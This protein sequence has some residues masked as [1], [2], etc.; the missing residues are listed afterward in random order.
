LSVRARALL[1]ALFFFLTMASYY[2]LKPVR[3]AIFLNTQG[4]DKV[5]HSHIAVSIVSFFAVQ[6]YAMVARRVPGRQLVVWINWLFVASILGFRGV[7]DWQPAGEAQTAFAWAYYI[8]VSIF[9]VFAVTLFWSFAHDVFTSDEGSRFYGY[10]GAGGILG[11]FLG[12]LATEH[13][14]NLVGLS[15]MFL[16]SAALLAPCGMIARYV[17]DRVPSTGGAKKGKGEASLGAVELFGKS[18]Y[19]CGIL[20]LV[21]LYQALAVLVDYQTKLVVKDAYRSTAEIAQFYGKIYWRVNILGTL[22]NLALTGFLQTRYGPWPGLMTLP[23]VGFCGAVGFLVHPVLAVGEWVTVLG[24]AVTYSIHQASKELLYLPVPSTE[25]YIAKGFID[26]FVFRLGNGAAAMWLVFA[27]PASGAASACLMIMAVTMGMISTAT[28][29]S[30][31]HR[32]IVA[33]NESALPKS[34]A[35]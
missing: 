14:V 30:I 4:I 10:I 22:I 15:N 19:L 6:V 17:A 20:V 24:L 33:G 31:R 26:T 9:S 5:A 13:L 34:A 1:C 35:E 18:K 27:V 2:I 12:G 25:R 8:W 28:W 23:I 11:G 21:F 29:L 7:F 32:E 16:L 3:E